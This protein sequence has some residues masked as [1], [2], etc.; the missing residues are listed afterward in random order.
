MRFCEDKNHNQIDA[1]TVSLLSSKGGEYLCIWCG[2]PLILHRKTLK[3]LNPHFSHYPDDENN[4][5]GYKYDNIFHPLHQEL[6]GIL[7]S[8]LNKGDTTPHKII[9]R[10]KRFENNE[11]IADVY[12]K[13]DLLPYPIAFEIQISPN[14]IEDVINRTV[15]YL[16]HQILPIWCFKFNYTAHFNLNSI[17]HLDDDIDGFDIRIYNNMLYILSLTNGKILFFNKKIC[18]FNP[19][20]KC[21]D[22]SSNNPYLPLIYYYNHDKTDC[23]R[24]FNKRFS[25]FQSDNGFDTVKNDLFSQIRLKNKFFTPNTS[26]FN[27]NSFLTNL[28]NIQHNPILNLM[29]SFQFNCNLITKVYNNDYSFINNTL[30]QYVITLFNQQSKL[31]IE[32]QKQLEIDRSK[33]KKQ[34]TIERFKTIIQNIDNEI[35]DMYEDQTEINQF[36]FIESIIFD[37]YIN[38]YDS[39]IKIDPDFVIHCVCLFKDYFF[40][41]RNITPNSDLDMVN[42]SFVNYLLYNRF[43]FVRLVEKYYPYYRNPHYNYNDDCL[44]TYDLS[45]MKDDLFDDLFSYIIRTTKLS[46]YQ[47]CIPSNSEI[48]D[49]SLKFTYKD[50]D[51]TIIFT[52]FA[53]STIF[54]IEYP[55]FRYFNQDIFTLSFSMPLKSLFTLFNKN[56]S[57]ITQFLKFNGFSRLELFYDNTIKQ[58]RK[59]NY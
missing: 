9:E 10:E 13:T 37:Y 16:T 57:N 38:N 40:I 54:M 29:D 55:I 46:L 18:T 53:L 30:D 35:D 19:I 34:F 28:I 1:H 32:Y 49:H 33:H 14:S 26:Q 11:R 22:F 6:E 20:S 36:R 12:W 42:C 48:L 44:F 56:I 23:I 39:I 4:C 2:K 47:R 3:H 15:W 17:V 8:F 25:K 59:I 51:D 24:F 7:E 21:E 31:Q 52:P 41:L 27:F 58:F 43:Y 5:V 45:S 50:T